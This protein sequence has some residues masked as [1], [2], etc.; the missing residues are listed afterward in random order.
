MRLTGVYVALLCCIFAV[1]VLAEAPGRRPGLYETV[2]EMTWQKSPLPPG[3]EMPPGMSS[4][5]GGGRHTSMTC[6]TAADLERYGAV[7][8]ENQRNCRITSMTKHAKGMTGEMEC[9]G[10]MTGKATVESAWL[11]DG[12]SKGKIHFI[13]TMQAG[14]DSLPVEWT[15]EYISSYKGPDCGSVKPASHSH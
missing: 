14:S 3:M 8:P 13:G 5:F 15:T 9:T 6:L 10:D 12:R 4:P 11:E 1:A 2:S 7:P